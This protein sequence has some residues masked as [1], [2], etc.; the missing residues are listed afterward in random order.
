MIDYVIVHELT[1]LVSPRHDALFAE[2]LERVLPR[3]RDTRRELNQLSLAAW[4]D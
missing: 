3:W 1:H 4:A 2:A